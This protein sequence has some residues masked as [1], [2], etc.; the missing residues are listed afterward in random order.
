MVT[1]R[2][3][4]E[5][6]KKF[7]DPKWETFSKCYEEMLKY[8]LTRRLLE[9]SHNPW[10]WG[11]SDTD[12]DSGGRSPTPAG[13]N[14]TKEDAT[15][16]EVEECAAVRLN[17]VKE[18]ESDP[19]AVPRLVLS[20]NE[21]TVQEEL[22][23][24]C[25]GAEEVNQRGLPV[26]QGKQTQETTGPKSQ[27]TS[28]QGRSQRVRPVPTQQIKEDSK[29]SRHPFVLYAS[30]EKD[31]DIARRKTH[32]IRPAASTKEI[33]ESALRAKTRREVERQLQSQRAERRRAKSAD[34]DKA[35]LKVVAPEYN[36][37]LTEY[38]RC[39]SA[40]SR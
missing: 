5:Y 20:G 22:E 28:R 38:M 19:T 10:F 7:K 9:H 24:G 11:G 16:R 26:L 25:G 2:I 15:E 27:L 34:V 18:R 14:Q 37:W 21:N 17:K 31:S 35:R 13:K 39:F 3:R 40:R 1:K 36:P 6:M 12:S 8:R 29:Q 33:H 23:R 30:G 32:N 4:S